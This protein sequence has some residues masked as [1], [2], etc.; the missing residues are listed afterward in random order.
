MEILPTQVNPVYQEFIGTPQIPPAGDVESGHDDDLILQPHPHPH[1]S[2]RAPWL[3]AGVLGLLTC[4]FSAILS[5]PSIP[6]HVFMDTLCKYVRGMRCLLPSPFCSSYGDRTQE[7]HWRNLVVIGASSH[8][9]CLAACAGCS[10]GLVSTSSLMIGAIQLPL[11]C[12]IY[13]HDVTVSLSPFT[14]RQTFI[15]YFNLSS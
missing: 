12:Y 2:Q 13:C 4:S 11:Q 1:F 6:V 7:V 10:D 15:K 14:R 3:R 9:N 5:V 8:Y